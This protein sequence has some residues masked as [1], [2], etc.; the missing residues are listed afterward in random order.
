MP[1]ATSHLEHTGIGRTVNA[2]RKLGGEVGDAA[3]ALV[4][5]WKEMVVQEDVKKEET[6][7][8]K[9]VNLHILWTIYKIKKLSREL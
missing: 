4:T 6:D 5:R 1:I 2:L 8:G 7:K 3:K 9:R